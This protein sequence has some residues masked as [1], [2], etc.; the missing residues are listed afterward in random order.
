MLHFMKYITSINK[1]KNS[2]GPDRAGCMD[3]KKRGKKMGGGEGVQLKHFPVVL[4]A[5]EH[6]FT[7]MGINELDM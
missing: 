1:Y 2:D 6:A 4:G 7:D 5:H 3:I